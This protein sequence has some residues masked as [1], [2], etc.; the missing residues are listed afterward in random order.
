[1]IVRVIYSWILCSSTQLWDRNEA[2]AP[3]SYFHI[4]AGFG[5]FVILMC[6][7]S[8]RPILLFLKCL[9]CGFLSRDTEG[10]SNSLGLPWLGLHQR[11]WSHLSQSHPRG[12]WCRS[13]SSS[14]SIVCATAQIIGL[15]SNMVV[16]GDTHFWITVC[17]YDSCVWGAAGCLRCMAL[18]N[19]KHKYCRS[20][21]FT[22]S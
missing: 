1:M 7:R 9:P 22:A 21:A 18:H 8:F 4:S 3:Q 5:D 17:I 16:A 11:D 13:R 10:F 20:Q 15:C 6:C 2:T 19:G 14:S 12:P